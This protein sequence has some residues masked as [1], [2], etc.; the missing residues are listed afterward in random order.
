MGGPAGRAAWVGCR[1]AG[2]GAVGEGG[3]GWGSDRCAN[4]RL[5]WAPE[6]ARPRCDVRGE[7]RAVLRLPVWRTR[8][9]GFHAHG[10]GHDADCGVDQLRCCRVG[11][12]D[13]PPAL[14]QVLLPARPVGVGHALAQLYVVEHMVQQHVLQQASAAAVGAGGRGGASLAMRS[15][16]P[17]PAQRPLARRA[18]TLHPA[19]NEAHPTRCA[20]SHRAPCSPAPWRRLGGAAGIAMCCARWRGPVLAVRCPASA[21]RPAS[22]HSRS[23]CAARIACRAQQGQ[24]CTPRAP[25]VRGTNNALPGSSVQRVWREPLFSSLN[26]EGLAFWVLVGRAAIWQLLLSLG[27]PSPALDSRHVGN[28]TSLHRKLAHPQRPHTGASR[29][30]LPGCPCSPT[31]RGDGRQNPRAARNAAAQALEGPVGAADPGFLG[32]CAR[33]CHTNRRE[34]LL[35]Q[36]ARAFTAQ[37]PA[38]ATRSLAVQASAQGTGQAVPGPAATDRR[39]LLLAAPAAAAAALALQSAAPA[40]ALAGQAAAVSTYLP[41][42]DQEGLY[43]FVPDKKKTPVSCASLTRAAWAAAPGAGGVWQGGA[44]P[45]PISNKIVHPTTTHARCHPRACRQS[46]QALWTPPTLTGSPCPAPGA[47][48]RWPTSSQVSAPRCRQA[49]LEDPL[50]CPPTLVVVGRA[51]NAGRR[52]TDWGSTIHQPHTQWMYGSPGWPVQKG[53][54]S[55]AC[56]DG[57]TPL[58][59][60]ARRQLLPTPLR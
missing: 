1:H 26:R 59:G 58:P 40:P 42:T 9:R 53:R 37:R 45:T 3:G 18:S 41:A 2:S 31:L 38:R 43:L 50:P 13:A 36:H 44:P 51:G 33:R 47:K 10:L 25:K 54:L 23:G 56:F 7:Q 20:P 48:L 24:A 35:Q 14:Q 52:Q 21:G 12:R 11:L 15:S 57:A 49:T 17:V 29:S 8:L 46:A 19:A 34:M 27:F 4:A 32:R 16:A 6:Q 30:I 55:S 60:R 22:A 5:G 39:S 28:V